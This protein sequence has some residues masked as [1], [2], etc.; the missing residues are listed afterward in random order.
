MTIFKQT[1]GFVGKGDVVFFFF[2]LIAKDLQGAM[3]WM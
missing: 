1:E 3:I 2:S